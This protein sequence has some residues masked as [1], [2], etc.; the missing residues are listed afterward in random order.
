M[1]MHIFP[2]I[3]NLMLILP[4]LYMS[5]VILVESQLSHLAAVAAGRRPAHLLL[6]PPRC[7]QSSRWR[8]LLRSARRDTEHRRRVRVRQDDYQFVAAAA[9]PP[10]WW[11]DHRRQGAFRR[12]RPAAV[13]R[14]GDARLPR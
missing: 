1:L 11:Q 10:A 13:E 14:G 8:E 7:G 2:N 12:R 9:G 3:V 6:H 5:L 4:T